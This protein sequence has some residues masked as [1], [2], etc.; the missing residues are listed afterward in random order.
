MVLLS[1]KLGAAPHQQNKEV[2]ST[3]FGEPL[4]S[5]CIGN[6]L[7][8]CSG[9]HVSSLIEIDRCSSQPFQDKDI[10]GHVSVETYW[11]NRYIEKNVEHAKLDEILGV[12]RAVRVDVE[13][14]TQL[15]QEQQAMQFIF[16]Q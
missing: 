11:Y 16:V 6:A 9:Y 10:F 4:C 13:R 5:S 12:M 8:H 2:P 3:N 15:L 1:P 14:N 7:G